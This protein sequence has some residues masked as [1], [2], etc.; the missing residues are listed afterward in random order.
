MLVFGDL[1][2]VPFTYVFQSFYLLK[3]KPEVQI[4]YE[5]AAFVVAVFSFG[6]YMFRWVNSQKDEFRRNPE[7]LVW[8]KKVSSLFP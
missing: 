3:H 2:W 1:S 5:Y 7:N 8:G 4:S 6:F